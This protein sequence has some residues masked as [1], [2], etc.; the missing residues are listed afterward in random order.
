MGLIL[1]LGIS[2]CS[3]HGQKREREKEE[4]MLSDQGQHRRTIC[5]PKLFLTCSSMKG[6]CVLLGYFPG[7]WARLSVRVAGAGGPQEF[8]PTTV[9]FFKNF[10]IFF[11][12]HSMVSQLHTHVYIL[13]SHITCSI[14]ID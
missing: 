4:S 5:F 2:I 6:R 1:G 3:G 10:F 8:S 14:I 13:F 11:L 7:S 12:L 9:D